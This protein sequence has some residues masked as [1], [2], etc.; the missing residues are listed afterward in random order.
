MSENTITCILCMEKEANTQDHTIRANWQNTT[1]IQH[2]Q[3]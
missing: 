2:N 3:L 1:V